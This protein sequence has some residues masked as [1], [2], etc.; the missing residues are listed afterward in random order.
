MF[1]LVF[2]DRRSS[3]V[4]DRSAS[5]GS[6]AFL[7]SASAP[8]GAR[9]R[10]LAVAIGLFVAFCA[11]LPFA[12]VPLPRV[13]AFIPIFESILA[14]TGLVTAGFLLVV[15]R[16]SRLRAV[17]CLASGYLFISLMTLPLMLAA[18]GVLSSSDPLGADPQIGAWLDAFRQ[19]GFP[20]FVSCYALLRRYEV[21]SGRLHKGAPADVIWAA[22]GAVAVVCLLTLLAATGHQFPPI[23]LGDGYTT[24]M[25]AAHIPVLLLCVAAAAL[26]GSRPPYTVLDLWLIVVVLAWM[27]G[28]ALDTVLDAGPFD[29]GF[30]AGRLYVLLAA[31]LVPIILLVEASRLY[32]RLDQALAVAGERNTE[33][34][35]SREELAQAQ[36]LEAIGQLTGGVAHDF[37]NLLTVVLGNLDLI[38]RAQ[39][40]A[41]KIER[42]AQGAMRAAQRGENLVRQLLTYARRQIT[43]PD[44][45]NLNQLIV[46][47][48]SLMHRVIGEQIEV[49]TMLSPVLA[50]AQIDPAQ[51]ETAMLNLVINARDAMA[52]GGR[53]TIETCNVTFD[54]QDA[55]NNP[56]LTAGPYVMIAVSDSGSGM[57]PEVLARAFDP[58]FTTKEVGKGS[59]LGLSQV[60]GFAKTAGGHV[61]IYSELG[62]GTTVKLYLPK[63][64]DRPV[65]P[66]IGSETASL[67]PASGHETILV[68]EDDEDVLVVAS[69]SLR[70]LGYRVVAASNATQALEILRGDQPVDLLLSDV[71][72]PGGMNGVQ[73]TVEA[74]R[75]RPELKVLL[76]SGYTA[77]ALSLEHG[78]PDNL[79]VVE[80]PYRR[81]E[82][83]TKLRLVIGG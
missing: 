23:M 74:R 50:P 45:V 61:K 13:E 8:L 18:P 19:A 72:M 66:E 12:R 36:R 65:V 21:A 11:L 28:G 83:A 56:E 55:A 43:R 24:A 48:E 37:N 52:G 34:A 67:R 5:E 71:I 69:E 79:N 49:V 41:E 51:F 1:L 9:R 17:L 47:I 54:R 77:A 76:T 26:L 44:T 82:L 14:L 58:F 29:I 73:L 64:S 10:A 63:S 62:I 70:E 16:R 80:K 35:R 32:G 4:N 2:G 6:D 53:I 20:V 46:N 30:Y 39:G 25:V 38:L 75:I 78:L 31:S 42:L 15:F 81:E 60:Y 7:V 40:D 59:G 33:L 68:V 27:F 57:T 22:A 3:N